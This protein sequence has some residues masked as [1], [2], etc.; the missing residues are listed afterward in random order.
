MTASGGSLVNS[1]LGHYRVE[2]LIGSGGM[3]EV[4]RA[5]DTVLGRA[6][7]L[8]VLLPHLVG[9]PDRLNRFIQEARS[10]SALNHPHVIAIYEIREAIPSRDD[11][12]LDSKPVHYIATELVSGQT[13]RALL[14]QRR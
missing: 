10:A 9:D 7:A 5:R 2:A 14:D 3:G 4:Y 8:K 6:V 1:T 13:L 11:A 12:P